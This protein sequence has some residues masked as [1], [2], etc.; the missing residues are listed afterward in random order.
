MLLFY[1][2][3]YDHSLPQIVSFRRSVIQRKCEEQTKK[4]VTYRT[5][6]I[7]SHSNTQL[8]DC[9]SLS[10]ELFFPPKTKKQLTLQINHKQ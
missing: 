9:L 10:R 2:Y 8:A 7:K 1:Y 3:S 5:V 6:A 4:T